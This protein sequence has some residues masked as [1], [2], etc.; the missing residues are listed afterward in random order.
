MPNENADDAGNAFDAAA[1]L[2]SDAAPDG[3]TPQDALAITLASPRSRP[4]MLL[5]PEQGALYAK[6]KLFGPEQA[7]RY[8]IRIM[9]PEQ[10]KLAFNEEAEDFLEE[11]ERVLDNVGVSDAEAEAQDAVC[12]IEPEGAANV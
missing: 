4:Y 3:A 5:T 2:A 10:A 8:Q 1:I 12:D 11:L 7:Q 9:T 6:G